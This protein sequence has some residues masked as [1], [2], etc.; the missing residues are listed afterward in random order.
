MAAVNDMYGALKIS[1]ESVL[2]H[3]VSVHSA[4]DEVNDEEIGG[5]GVR[6]HNSSSRLRV[7]HLVM[8]EIELSMVRDRAR[9]LARL[10]LMSH[11]HDEPFTY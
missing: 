1:W 8:A 6:A 3:L 5:G 10:V 9:D 4:T 7:P 11:F 2:V